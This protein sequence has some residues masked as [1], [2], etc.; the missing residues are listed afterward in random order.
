MACKNLWKVT[1]VKNAGKLTKGMTVEIIVTGTSAHPNA[2]QII[3][4]IETKYNITVSSCHCGNSNL[5]FTK[6]G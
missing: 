4:A 5:E 3:E 2:K 1:A 6:L